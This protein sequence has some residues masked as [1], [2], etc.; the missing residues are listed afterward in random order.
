MCV[1]AGGGGGSIFSLKYFPDVLK[2]NGHNKEKYFV[3]L[4]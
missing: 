4:I 2:Q 1:G 3:N